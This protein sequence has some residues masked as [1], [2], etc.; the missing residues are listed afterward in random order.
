M[1]VHIPVT[2][3][4]VPPQSV[5]MPLTE[6]LVRETLRRA[7]RNRDGRLSKNELEIALK[8]FGSRWASYRARRCFRH[9]DANH[10]GHISAAELDDLVAYILKWH[11]GKVRN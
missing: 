3:R 2:T 8:E 1:P 7:D 4:S 5:A 10:D 6:E 9:A 11:A